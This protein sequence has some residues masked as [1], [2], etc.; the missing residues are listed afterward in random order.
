MRDVAIVGIGTTQ[1]GR[2]QWSLLKMMCEASHEALTDAALGARKVDAVVVANMGGARNNRQAGLASA[3]ADRLNLLPVPAETVENGPASGASAVK[4][5]FQA[6]ASGMHDLVLVCGGERMQEVNNFEA[7]EFVSYLSHRYAEYVYG[8]TLPALAGMFA[9]LFMERHKFGPEHLAMVAIK[10]HANGLKNPRAHLRIAVTMEG[11]LTG[12]DAGMNNPWVA[13][14]LRFFDCCPVSDGASAVVL[15]PAALARE[16]Q[17]KPVKI[18][19]IGQA[20]DTHAVHERPDPVELTAVR[21]AAEKAYAMAGVGAKDIQV[22]ELHDAFTILEIAESEEAGLFPKGQGHRALERGDSQI[23]GRMPINP[24]GGLK[25]RGHPVGNTGVSQIVEL[26]RQ[27]RGEAGDYQVP[28]QPK[29]GLAV[30]FGGFGNNVIA[31]VLKGG[32]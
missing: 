6:V 23:G 10:N 9:R 24:S 20:T 7:T 11:L 19:G 32:V 8:V 28:G 22:A 1:F 18:A 15:A 17:K 27:L 2:A 30:N 13:D 5:G 26:A 29:T 14:P 25:A 16:L 4:M 3:L 31:T 12:P 21:L